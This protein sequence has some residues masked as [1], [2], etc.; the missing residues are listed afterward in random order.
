MRLVICDYSGHPFQVELSR[1]LAGR[2]HSVLHLHF[3]EFQTP[4]GATSPLPGDPLTFTVE[5]IALGRK[6]EKDRFV[7]RRFQEVAV[8]KLAAARALA[9]RPDGVIGCNMPLDAQRQLQRRCARAG[10]AFIFWLQDIYS[11]AIGHYLTERLGLPGRA[12]GGYYR[13]LEGS[14]LRASAAVIAI[15]ESFTAAL[16]GWGVEPGNIHVIPNWAP[17]SEIYPVAKDNGW[18]RRHDLAGRRVALY[19]GTLGLKHDPGLLLALARAAEP[20]GLQVVVVSEGKA[21]DW[22]ARE[23]KESGIGN[24]TILPFQPMDIYP[25]LLG[26]GDILLAMVGAEAARFAVPSKILS[27]LAA[28]RPIVAAIAAD[29]DAARV[30]VEADAGFIAP[31]GDISAFVKGVLD[32]VQDPEI[33]RRLGKNGRDFAEGH[34][35]IGP[36]ADRFEAVLIAALDRSASAAE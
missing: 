12:I 17:L 26:T 32:L 11:A 1:C 7:R 16:Q 31:P 27:Y 30:I 2:G 15:S 18:A 3:A 35:A 4:K 21:A 33:C 8:G 28:G 25:E 5:G 22:L 20:A 36:I 14:I 23:A 19:T 10:I 6:F 9:F 29:N 34:F 24:L 13:Y